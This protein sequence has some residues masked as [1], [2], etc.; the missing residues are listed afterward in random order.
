MTD[1]RMDQI[2]GNLLRAGVAAAAVVVTAGGV[3]YLAEAA[4]DRPSYREFRPAVRGLHSLAT[5]PHP[6]ALILLG[7]LILIVTP[8]ARVVFSLV[9]FALERDRVYMAITLTVLAIL[10]YSLGTSW[11]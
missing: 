2:I 8:V 11:L 1:T 7:L 9:A 10:F 6:Q 3:W 5:L 4:E